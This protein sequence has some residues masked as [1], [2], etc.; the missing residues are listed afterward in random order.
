MPKLSVKT[1]DVLFQY[2]MSMNE[3]ISVIFKFCSLQLRDFHRIHPLIS[4]S[5]AITLANAFVHS[6][7]DYRKS[8]FYGLPKYPI[9]RLQKIKSTTACIIT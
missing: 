2:D 6:H 3:H 1:L 4:K 7:L 9:H 8:L 5:A